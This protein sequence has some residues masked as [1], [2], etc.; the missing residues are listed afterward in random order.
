MS[1]EDANVNLKAL[2]S[3]AKRSHLKILINYPRFGIFFKNQ[4]NLEYHLK[5]WGWGNVES[6]G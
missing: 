2:T 5:S 3:V 1:N 6:E 4:D